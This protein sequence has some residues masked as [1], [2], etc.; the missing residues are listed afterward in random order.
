MRCVLGHGSSPFLRIGAIHGV[1]NASCELSFDPC[2]Q[3][4]HRVTLKQSNVSS[5]DLSRI[6]PFWNTL[7]GAVDRLRRQSRPRKRAPAGCT[8]G[9]HQYG[10]Q[11]R[12]NCSESTTWPQKRPL[13]PQRSSRPLLN[14]GPAIGFEGEGMACRG[15][16]SARSRPR[17]PRLTVGQAGYR[18]MAVGLV[19]SVGTG[20]GPVRAVRSP[21]A[22]H[23]CTHPGP[24][25]APRDLCG[26]APTVRVGNQNTCEKVETHDLT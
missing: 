8:E 17:A 3:R 23:A 5:R 12:W 26:G 13:L 18:G 1:P 22:S 20:R 25:G 19:W 2:H 9:L 24:G 4:L 10:R 21:S 11:R 15:E 6:W 14:P 7:D 16:T